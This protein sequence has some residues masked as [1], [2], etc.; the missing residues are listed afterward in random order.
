MKVAILAGGH[1]TRLAEETEIRPKPM[2][3]IGGRPILWHIMK[4]YAH[5]NHKE[6][7]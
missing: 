4:H 2:V 5:Y 7:V 1:G 3:E 6:F